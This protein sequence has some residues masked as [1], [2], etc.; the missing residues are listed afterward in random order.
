MEEVLNGY[1]TDPNPTPTLALTATELIR[2]SK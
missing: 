1:V 2:K